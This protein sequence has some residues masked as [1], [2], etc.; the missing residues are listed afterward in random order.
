MENLER[1]K[2]N[3]HSRV[4]IWTLDFEQKHV[5][6]QKVFSVHFLLYY[7]ELVDGRMNHSEK[8]LPVITYVKQ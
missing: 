5:D 7:F 4:G 1:A 3:W 2:K 6:I 8:V